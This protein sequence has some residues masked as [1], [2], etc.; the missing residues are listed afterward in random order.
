MSIRNFLFAAAF[1]ACTSA[2]A[3]NYVYS[4]QVR[5]LVATV[6]NDWLSPTV[7]QL[8]NGDVLNISFDELSHTYHRF[9]YHIEHC[10]FDWS[11]SD[12]IF[13]NDYIQGF[14]DNPIENYK[15]SLNTTV[16]YTHYSVQIPND[17]CQ[18]K[19]SGNYKLSILDEDND[20]EKVAEVRFMVLDNEMNVGL[21]A[22]TN[23][24]IDLNATHQQVGMEV[25]YNS[26]SVTNMDEQLRTVVMQN[27]RED[28]WKV[29]VRPNLINNKGLTWTH[30]KDL[31]F[32]AGNEYRKYEILDVS[33]PTMGID[34]I[35]WDGH[36]Y[37][38]F[39]VMDE[40]RHNYLTDED[41]DGCFLI[42][43]SDNYEIDYTCDYV[44]VHYKLKSPELDQGR[45]I[46][47]GQ[48]ATDANQ[49]SYVMQYDS[50]DGTYNA[51][52]MQKLG[53]YNYQYLQLL[54][55]GS[56]QTPPSESNFYQTE[57]RYQAFVYYKGTGERT[58]RLVGYRQLIM[59]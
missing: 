16:P 56:T 9:I 50:T 46:I 25:N 31:I 23:T 53:Y 43:N 22:S 28:N 13:E 11:A 39:T 41:A 19:M 57:N 35:E 58:W 17:R 38:A 40:P 52:I 5:T 49:E 6:N 37:H 27:N 12:G 32:D 36:H 4:P 44:N 30:N 8:D 3:R 10:E 21:S 24:D 54:D 48:L 51:T 15:N 2:Q 29:N 1:L 14:N 34:H 42:R 47:N 26:V 55:D 7:M 20:N 45:M 18:L 59:K 33:H